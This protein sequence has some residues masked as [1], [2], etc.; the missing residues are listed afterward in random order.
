V[1]IAVPICQGRV[2]PVFD[3]ATRLLVVRLKGGV[4]VERREVALFEDQPAGIV[5]TLEELGVGTLVCG[6]ISLLSVC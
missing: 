5:R 1:L 6:A 3:V 2:S 4:E